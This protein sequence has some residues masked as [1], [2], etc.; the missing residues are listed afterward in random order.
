MK[1]RPSDPD[2]PIDLMVWFIPLPIALML[3]ILFNRG[4][5]WIVAYAAAVLMVMIGAVK[6]FRAKLPLYRQG[7]YFTW[8]PGDLPEASLP[9]YRSAMRW[10]VA[11]VGVALLLLLPR[12]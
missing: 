7:R 2:F 11:G 4:L 1:T 8:G 6:L 10:I 12:F 5:P 3:W 9:L